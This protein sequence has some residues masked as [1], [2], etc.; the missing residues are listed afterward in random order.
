MSNPYPKSAVLPKQKPSFASSLSAAFF[1]WLRSFGPVLALP[2]LIAIAVSACEDDPY[3]PPPFADIG[4]FDTTNVE[5]VKAP[6]G[7]IIYFHEE[8]SGDVIAER[9]IVR[10][11]FTGRTTDGEIIDSSK[12]GDIDDPT[13]LQLSN[14]ITGFM[15]GIVGVMIEDPETGKPVRKHASREG[16]VRTIVIPP[17]LGYG[18]TT[19][20]LN[21][22]TLIFDIDVLR[23]MTAD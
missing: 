1:S 14:M 5:H 4:P 11:R 15:Q 7:L 20:H 3:S 18:G 17:P 19:S 21:Q 10:I 23:I 6:N 2:G 16:A 22:D 9:H 12:R 8:G 13:S